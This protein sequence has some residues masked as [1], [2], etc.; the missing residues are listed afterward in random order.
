MSIQIIAN[1][2][3]ASPSPFVVHPSL[4]CY[5]KQR[6]KQWSS[7]GTFSDQLTFRVGGVGVGVNVVQGLKTQG[8]VLPPRIEAY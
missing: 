4:H 1:S 5:E 3:I 6:Q 8:R 2:P 7:E